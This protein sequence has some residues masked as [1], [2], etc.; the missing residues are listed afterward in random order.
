MRPRVPE[1]EL[2]RTADEQQK[3]TRGPCHQRGL[4]YRS[5]WHLQQRRCFSHLSASQGPGTLCNLRQ[6][7]QAPN[8]HP[9]KA[10]SLVHGS[11]GQLCDTHADL[12]STQELPTAAA[13]AQSK[14]RKPLT[15]LCGMDFARIYETS[16]MPVGDRQASCLHLRPQP[17]TPYR[18]I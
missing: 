14:N 10:L 5:S 1:P 13:A 16:G 17:P 4:H 9:S 6:E 7:D 15:P 12:E 2:I 8:I 11:A 3:S 18:Q